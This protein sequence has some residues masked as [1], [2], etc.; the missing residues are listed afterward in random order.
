[1]GSKNIQAAAYNGARTVYN[2]IPYKFFGLYL[3]TNCY[4]TYS[5]VTNKR[6]VL[7]MCRQEKFPN[8]NEVVLNHEICFEH[9]I[10][11]S[12]QESFVNSILTLSTMTFEDNK[13]AHIQCHLWAT[14]KRLSEL[15]RVSMIR[16]ISIFI[17]PKKFGNF[18]GKIS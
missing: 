5:A 12:C 16:L 15:G 3:E 18:G 8:S 6:G 1:M 7:I 11:I 10:C 4:T 9:Y 13:N 14:F 17:P 2:Y